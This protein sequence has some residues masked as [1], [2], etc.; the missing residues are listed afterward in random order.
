MKNESLFS[1]A[2]RER[3]QNQAPLAARL[4][5]RTFDEDVGQQ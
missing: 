4:R 1:G 3:L 2:A 5:P